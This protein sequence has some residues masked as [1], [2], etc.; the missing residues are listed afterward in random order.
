MIVVIGGLC[1]L[2]LCSCYV[3]GFFCV[4]S[5][6]DDKKTF[7]SFVSR[8]KSQ[9]IRKLFIEYIDSNHD[10]IFSTPNSISIT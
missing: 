3:V 6:S 5:F 9:C 10:L 7:F 8:L 1:V 4:G 2:F